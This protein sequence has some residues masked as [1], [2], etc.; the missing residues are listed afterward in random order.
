MASKN[1]WLR[2]ECRTL[3]TKVVTRRLDI[4]LEL[5]GDP[6]LVSNLG[7]LK[8]LPGSVDVSNGLALGGDVCW[9]TAQAELGL[10]SA[11]EDD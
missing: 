5:G 8:T 4:P 9:A 11:V 10:E 2:V 1:A 6:L 3:R 7:G